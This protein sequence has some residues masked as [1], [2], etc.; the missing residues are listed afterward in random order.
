MPREFIR[1]NVNPQA[2]YSCQAFVV[3][4]PKGIE[5]GIHAQQLLVEPHYFDG[6]RVYTHE[7]MNARTHYGHWNSHPAMESWRKVRPLAYHANGQ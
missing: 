5:R 2:H 1:D 4:T 6:I 3:V 7:L